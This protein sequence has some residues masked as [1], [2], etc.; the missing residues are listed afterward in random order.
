MKNLREMP[1]TLIHC[2]KLELD[3]HS[4]DSLEIKGRQSHQQY[5][6]CLQGQN[7]T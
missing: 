5:S 6:W 3:C 2:L 4:C 1:C 7:A